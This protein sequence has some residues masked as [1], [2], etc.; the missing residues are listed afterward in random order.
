MI[1][2]SQLLSV[3]GFEP[4]RKHVKLVRHKDSRFDLEALRRTPWFDVYQQYQSR[5]VFDDCTQIVSFIGEEYPKSRFVG[6]YDVGTRRTAVD[7]PRPV[8][9]PYPDLTAEPPSFP[10]LCPRIAAGPGLRVAQ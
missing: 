6:V 9:C 5:P 10:Q 3:R 2:V 8:D 1:P 4:N 7:V